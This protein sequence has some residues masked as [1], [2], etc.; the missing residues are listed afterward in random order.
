M[1]PL[2]IKAKRSAE[3]RS[4]PR[5]VAENITTRVIRVSRAVVFTKFII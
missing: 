5:A 3:T 4:K 2:K 1:N